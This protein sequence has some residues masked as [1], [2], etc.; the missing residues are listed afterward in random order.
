MRQTFILDYLHLDD[1][2]P[3]DLQIQPIWTTYVFIQR[4]AAFP[5]SHQ[6]TSNYLAAV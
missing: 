1:G 3:S 6:R 4:C 5:K 2:S